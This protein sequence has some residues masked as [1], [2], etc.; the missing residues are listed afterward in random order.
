MKF[1]SSNRVQVSFEKKNKT[2]ST[3]QY[4]TTQRFVYYFF[5]NTNGP[6]IKACN[7]LFLNSSI[8]CG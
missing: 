2:C 1:F 6:S 3:M 7:I 4:Y 5:C 8:R